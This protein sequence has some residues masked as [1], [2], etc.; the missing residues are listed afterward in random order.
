MA[1]VVELPFLEVLFRQLAWHG[2][3]RAIL[4]VGSQKEA[5]Q[6]YFGSCTLGLQLTYS[7]EERP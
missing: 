5:I 3:N 4:A 1:A 7:P 6:S 2:F